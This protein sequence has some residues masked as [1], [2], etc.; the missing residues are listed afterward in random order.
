MP[1]DGRVLNPATAQ[2]KAD[3]ARALK[4]SRVA[5]ASQRTERL[6]QRNPSRLERQISDLKSSAE[7]SSTGGLN[8]RAKRQLEELERQ[9]VAVK[10]A[11]EKR[12]EHGPRSNVWG[13][14]GKGR[15]GGA[16]GK[17][18]REGKPH[19]RND[20]VESDGSQTDESVRNIPMPRDTP[21]PIPRLRRSGPHGST[22][23]IH[24]VGGVNPNSAPLGYDRGR[25]SHE[26]PPKPGSHTTATPKITYEAK[27]MVRDLRKEA[28]KAFMPAVVARNVKTPK[29]EGLGGPVLDEHEVEIFGGER[30]GGVE[31]DKGK[32]E[33]GGGEAIGTDGMD[34]TLELLGGMNKKDKRRLEEEEKRFSKEVQME[35]IRDEDL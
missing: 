32:V 14:G 6:A 9:L 21:P 19:Q 24:G 4:K 7:R 27:A 16:L 23:N 29:G 20:N 33:C 26:L 1:K 30:Y 25:I 15:G 10:K 8:E 31:T 22:S 2:L 12:G 3:K 28:V 17:R 34:A 5:I 35:E 18:S 13:N 11:R